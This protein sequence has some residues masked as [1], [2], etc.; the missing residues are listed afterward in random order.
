MMYI[1]IEISNPF[2]IQTRWLLLDLFAQRMFWRLVD[3]A[4]F[5]AQFRGEHVLD[6]DVLMPCSFYSAWSEYEEYF[7]DLYFPGVPAAERLII[8]RKAKLRA[9]EARQGKQ[10]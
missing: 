8:R 9:Q 1:P 7:P 2:G 6:Y 5:G 10:E 3:T 4:G